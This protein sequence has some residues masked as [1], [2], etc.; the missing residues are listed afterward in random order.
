[1]KY[2]IIDAETKRVIGIVDSPT[3]IDGAF[4]D[5]TPLDLT[6]YGA[7]SLGVDEKTKAFLKRTE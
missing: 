2:R 6:P 7:E 3:L 1:M 4:P 5:K